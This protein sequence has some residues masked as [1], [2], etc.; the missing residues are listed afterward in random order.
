MQNPKIFLGRGHCALKNG[1]PVIQK[2]TGSGVP[3]QFEH[4]RAVISGLGY[5]VTGGVLLADPDIH[6]R[7]TWGRYT[8]HSE[9]VCTRHRDELEIVNNGDKPW[10]QICSIMGP[11]FDDVSGS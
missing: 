8:V 5:R 10:K 7:E 2:R 11:A 4:W 3:V 6:G 1:V 9:S